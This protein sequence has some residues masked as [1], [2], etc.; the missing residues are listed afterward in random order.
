V[1]IPIA[2]ELNPDLTLRNYRIFPEIGKEVQVEDLE[3]TLGSSS[4]ICAAELARILILYEIIPSVN[5]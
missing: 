4:A 3:L 2:G 1:K 5:N